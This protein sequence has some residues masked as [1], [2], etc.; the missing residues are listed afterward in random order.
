MKSAYEAFA[1]C[2]C[3]S[4]R[5][6]AATHHGTVKSG[7]LADNL[8]PGFAMRMRRAGNRSVSK[9]QKQHKRTDT[10]QKPERV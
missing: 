1:R 8:S 6:F 7:I 10:L 4:G 3:W 2:G 5:G 9:K